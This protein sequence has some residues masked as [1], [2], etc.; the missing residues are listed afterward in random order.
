VLGNVSTILEIPKLVNNPEENTDI[1]EIDNQFIIEIEGLSIFEEEYINSILDP[2][3]LT[4][5]T[6]FILSSSSTSEKLR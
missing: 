4:V 6:V 1:G 2:D 5:S 3:V